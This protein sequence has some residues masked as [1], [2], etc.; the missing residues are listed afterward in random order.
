[1]LVELQTFLDPRIRVGMKLRVADKPD[2][3]A[4]AEDMGR[5]F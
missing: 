2:A 5:V 3:T 4:R 1:M